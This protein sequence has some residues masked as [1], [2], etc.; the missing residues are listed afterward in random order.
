MGATDAP[1]NEATTDPWFEAQ[2]SES[3]VGGTGQQNTGRHSV[4]CQALLIRDSPPDLRKV[5]TSVLDQRVRDYQGTRDR[6]N[7]VMQSSG[8]PHSSCSRPDV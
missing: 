8:A 3:M 2:P 6:A 7:L 5:R 1:P 4:P